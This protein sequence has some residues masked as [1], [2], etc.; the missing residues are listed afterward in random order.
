MKK[1][2]T[3]FLFSIIWPLQLFKLKK[4]QRNL[5]GGVNFSNFYTDDVDD[6]NVLTDLM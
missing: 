2:L 6:N 1:I 3:H 4:M 5:G